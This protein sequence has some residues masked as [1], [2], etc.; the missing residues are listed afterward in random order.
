MAENTHMQSMQ[1]TINKLTKQSKGYNDQ[2]AT[3]TQALAS[4][5]VQ[6]A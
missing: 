3:M 4:L 2:L 5:Q 1:A 6:L